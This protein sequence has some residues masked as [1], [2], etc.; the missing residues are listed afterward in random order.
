MVCVFF[1]NMPCASTCLVVLLSLVYD[2]SA[3]RLTVDVMGDAVDTTES[4]EP[5]SELPEFAFGQPDNERRCE[6]SRANF[7]RR[8]AIERARLPDTNTTAILSATS[9]T[10]VQMWGAGKVFKNGLEFD[11][12]W[13]RDGSVDFSPLAAVAVARLQGNPCLA[14]AQ[15]WLSAADSL[16]AE[17][18][19]M[20]IFRVTQAILSHECD[21]G[22]DADEESEEEV[23]RTLMAAA[24]EDQLLD[25]CDVIEELSAETE[26]LVGELVE[27]TL[28]GRGDAAVVDAALSNV[29]GVTAAL[30]VFGLSCAAM[31]PVLL[32]VVGAVLCMTKWTAKHLLGRA[33]SDVSGCVG[34]WSTHTLAYYRSAEA[35][36]ST[37]AVSGILS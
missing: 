13:T 6:S 33:G 19:A 37:C 29:V 2:V 34:W 20:T 27:R 17:D 14:T 16:G 35:I 3:A 30:L 25:L 15:G 9:S 11:C 22:Q 7:V 5:E 4:P 24:A 31:T 32:M 21:E 18:Q 23:T 1:K 12:A 26:E 28:E 8:L 36:T 10:L